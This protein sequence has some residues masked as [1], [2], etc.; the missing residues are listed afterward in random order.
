VVTTTLHI[1]ID[2]STTGVR[3]GVRLADESGVLHAVAI[4][5]GATPVMIN[6]VILEQIIRAVQARL[7]REL[8]L[9]S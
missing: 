6:R 3:W 8:T 2:R 1:D 9:Q 7:A 5:P 4:P